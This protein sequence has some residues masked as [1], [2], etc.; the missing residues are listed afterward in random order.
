MRG[1]AVG[2]GSGT[3][4]FLVTTDWIEKSW[5]NKVMTPPTVDKAAYGQAPETRTALVSLLWI[6]Q[7]FVRPPQRPQR[8]VR[9][10]LS[11]IRSRY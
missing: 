6:P 3:Q 9:C 4:R 10:R 1:D 11:L 8:H 2:S 5:L 7:M